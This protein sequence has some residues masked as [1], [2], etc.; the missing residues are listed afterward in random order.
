[1][2]DRITHFL[3][4]QAHKTIRRPGRA[5]RI[6]ASLALRRLILPLVYGVT[7]YFDGFLNTL[8]VH[9]VIHRQPKMSPR[10]T[11]FYFHAGSHLLQQSRPQAAWNCFEKC[12]RGSTD[13]V[14]FFTAAVCLLHG[15]GR[16]WDALSC[17]A[18]ANDLNLQRSARFG[19][20]RTRYRILDSFWVTNIG[21]TAA[22]DYVIK[23]GY[24]EGRNADDTI[25]YVAP[26]SRVANRCLL[27]QFRPYLNLIEQA[28]DLPFDEAAVPALR[29]DFVWPFGP[30][31]STVH[32][33]GVA[34]KTYRRWYQ[35][36]RGA[37]LTLSSQLD[38][39]GW[40]ALRSKGV[41][42][43]AW[44]VALHVREPRSKRHHA[45]LHQVLNADV[46]SYLPAVAE[47]TRRGGW[48]IRM[49]DPNMVPL[50]ALPNVIDYCHS[51]LRADW[52]DV[53]IAARCRFMLGTSS[54]PAYLPPLYGVPSVLTNW[55]PPAQRP[56]HPMDIFMPKMIRNMR[57]GRLLTL[58][59]TLVDPFSFCHAQNYLENVE[60]VRVED[61]APELIRSAVVEMFERIEDNWPGGDGICALRRRADN[62]Y[63]SHG[64]YGMGQLAA[65]FLQNYGSLI[66]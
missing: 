33:W 4:V 29:Y 65:G 34:A 19:S 31:G 26:G 23:L 42:D 60:R 35:S 52:M 20:A 17:F 53:F 7:P 12:L 37:L 10:R 38:A 55:W 5:I 8:R 3:L 43:G 2:L 13:P 21:H 39:R 51:D 15:L 14:H 49:G 45:D 36:G 16:A 25:L 32:F 46:T 30:D 22:L 18:H 40:Q 41:P 9:D 54:G 63:D 64:A 24:Q 58:S 6:P 56:W 48:V 28:A 57:D 47:I 27:E 59:E 61:N 66:N 50:P 1:M 62:I 44:F 11:K